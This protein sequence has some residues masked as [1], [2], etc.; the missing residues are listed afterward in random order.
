MSLHYVTEFKYLGHIITNNSLDD[1]D[2]KREM[3]L[4]FARSNMLL[5]RYGKCSVNVKLTLFRS[6]CMCF[7]DISLWNNYSLTVLSKN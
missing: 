3:R 5:R 1:A 6:F 7:Y 4:L 2:I